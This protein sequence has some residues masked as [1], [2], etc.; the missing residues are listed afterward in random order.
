M[1]TSAN[2][3]IISSDEFEVPDTEGT[4]DISRMVDEIVSRPTSLIK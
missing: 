2:A 1:E 4:I 3:K